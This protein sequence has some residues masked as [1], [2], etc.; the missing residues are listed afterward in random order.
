M[1]PRARLYPYKDD[2]VTEEDVRSGWRRHIPRDVLQQLKHDSELFVSPSVCFSQ[3]TPYRLFPSR[4][5][6]L[7][8]ESH[9]ELNAANVV[10]AVECTPGEFLLNPLNATGGATIRVAYDHPC[11]KDYVCAYWTG[12]AGPGTPYLSCQEMGADGF[13]DIAVPA[14]AI[15][16][17]F[18]Q[19]VSV[20]YTVLRNGE[21]FSSPPRDIHILN[22]SD[23]PT[24]QVAQAT[25]NT[26]DLHTFRGDAELTVNPWWFINEV[27]P[28]WLWVTGTLA[29]DTAYSVQVL[30][31]ESGSMAGVSEILP[32]R[33]LQK[34]A[35]CSD[36]RVHFAVNFNGQLDKTSAEQ[37]PVLELKLVQE[38]RVLKA[39]SVRE[40]VGRE[41]TIWNGRDGVTV[42]V[43]YEGISHH[44]QISVCWKRADGTCLPLASQPGNSAVG[45]VDFSIPREAVIEAAG[46]TVT[47]NYTVT[48]ACQMQ[49]SADLNLHVS[50][51][52]RLPTPVVLEAT[53]SA[54]QGG[55]LDLQTFTG[56]ARIT[57]N[58]TNFAKA[59]WF[60][61]VGQKAWLRVVGILEN[62][63]AHTITVR[64]DP[65]V[66]ADEVNNGL[67]A[68]LPRPELETLKDRSPLTVTCDVSVDGSSSGTGAVRFPAL[69]LTVVVPREIIY[70]NF[71]SQP[72]RL[73]SAG[74]SLSTSTMT[75][76]HLSGPGLSGITTNNNATPWASGQVFAFW[77]K[78]GGELAPQVIEF[79]LNTPCRSVQ[80]GVVGLNAMLPIRFYG[81]LGEGLGGLI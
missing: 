17:N 25:G 72:N 66:T 36:V 5:L 69:E 75:I 78:A 47:I 48:S 28:R 46:K 79:N 60:A 37:F 63:V 81:A 68:V 62:G 4:V 61:L 15:S 41:L 30:Q 23:L 22:I 16:A 34:L 1:A 50:M 31:G 19:T 45:H 43:E 44:Q 2:P 64:V 49:T 13:V 54:I 32:R 7:L 3:V 77:Y 40:A 59:W 9:L 18:L 42:R 67:L 8:T 76:K 55:I 39:A 21:T 58:D 56:N 20:H 65:S 14:A 73:I 51:P 38:D 71:E 6:T 11:P 70:E 29:D 57:V 52:V 74:Q 33:E 12:T 80:F 53:P 26:L 35:D 24:P 10:Q 27:H